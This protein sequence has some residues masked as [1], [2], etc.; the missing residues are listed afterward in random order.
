MTVYRFDVAAFLWSYSMYPSGITT[1]RSHRALYSVTPPSR[2]LHTT[3]YPI[4]N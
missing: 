3:S 4:A 1:S 2:P